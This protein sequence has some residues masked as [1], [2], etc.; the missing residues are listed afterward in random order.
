MKR[1]GSAYP[2]NTDTKGSH[3]CYCIL[4]HYA[5]C[6]PHKLLQPYT[7][8]PQAQWSCSTRPSTVLSLSQSLLS[9]R[10]ALTPAKSFSTVISKTTS[11]LLKMQP[12]ITL[13]EI[14]CAHKMTHSINAKK[15]GLFFWLPSNHAASSGFFASPKNRLSVLLV[16]LSVFSRTV[17]G[18]C[19]K[20]AGEVVVDA[21]PYFDQGYDGSGVKE[22]VSYML[23]C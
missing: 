7:L 21:L 15:R 10:Q 20:M 2:T 1:Q 5:R 22:A 16:H 19:W 23:R 3:A 12:A 17:A 8:Q 6:L 18:K 14:I 4:S 13:S 9:C 11:H